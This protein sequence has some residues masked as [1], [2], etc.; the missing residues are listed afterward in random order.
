MQA[1]LPAGMQQAPAD[2]TLRKTSRDNSYATYVL[3]GRALSRKQAACYALCPLPL[4]R[5]CPCYSCSR[6][7]KSPCH[8][9]CPV[10]TLLLSITHRLSCR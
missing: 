4:L 2:T 6:Q 8:S 10:V 1:A 9:I 3:Y 7:H 5:P